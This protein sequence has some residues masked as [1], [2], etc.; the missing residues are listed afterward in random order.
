LTPKLE[1]ENNTIMASKLT[2]ALISLSLKFSVVESDRALRGMSPCDQRKWHLDMGNPA[3]HGCS[4]SFK[5]P[6]WFHNQPHLFYE[7]SEKCCSDLF[8]GQECNIIDQC[9]PKEFVDNCD[10]PKWHFDLDTKEGCTNNPRFPDAWKGPN[11]AADYL[12]ET[13]ERCCEKFVKRGYPC[14]H[15]DVCRKRGVRELKIE[16]EEF[17]DSISQNT[18][19]KIEMH[20][21]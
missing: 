8:E 1:P 17:V 13:P 11:V 4:N 18:T 3:Q 5:V 7:S 2:L 14:G 21:S 19:A 10:S 15:H 6:S 20:I 9:N 12:F 16:R